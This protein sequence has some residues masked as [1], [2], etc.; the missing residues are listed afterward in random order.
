MIVQ[1]KTSS[2]EIAFSRH[3]IQTP[4]MYLYLYNERDPQEYCTMTLKSTRFGVLYNERDPQESWM[5][6]AVLSTCPLHTN[7]GCGE[8]RRIF[9]GPW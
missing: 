2:L 3:K 1:T 6:T 8:E 9:I 7:S 5:D 4:Y